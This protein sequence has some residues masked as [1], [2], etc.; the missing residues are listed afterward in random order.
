MLYISSAY[1]QDS[2]G[3]K[4]ANAFFDNVYLNCNYS[5][6][7]YT[8]FPKE[9]N[10][11]HNVKVGGALFHSI[12]SNYKIGIGITL[13][14]YEFY[15]EKTPSGIYEF[16]VSDGTQIHR[17]SHGISFVNRFL[18]FKN[19]YADI[20]IQGNVNSMYKKY[21]LDFLNDKRYEENVIPSFKYRN[22]SFYLDMSI[23]YRFLELQLSSMIYDEQTFV[24][25]FLGMGFQYKL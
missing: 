13:A 16:P 8:N 4:Q 14:E 23:G 17:L 18:F 11:F 7:Y 19:F 3:S 2:I 24:P 6:L 21:Y 20:A 5:P 10:S 9:Y 22:P 25:F 12:S 15:Y 1:S